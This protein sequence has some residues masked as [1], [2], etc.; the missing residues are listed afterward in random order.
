MVSKSHKIT[1][2]LSHSSAT[3]CWRSQCKLIQWSG[4]VLSTR[5]YQSENIDKCVCTLPGETSQ[6]N[7][8]YPIQLSCWVNVN[9]SKEFHQLITR[10]NWTDDNL[11]LTC[12]RCHIPSRRT[13]RSAFLIAHARRA[14]KVE[15]KTADNVRTDIYL[16]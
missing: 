12:A 15:R 16:V 1:W 3:E 13:K 14:A 10:N 2:E 11:I 9:S 8:L 7:E 6:N 4:H 5:F